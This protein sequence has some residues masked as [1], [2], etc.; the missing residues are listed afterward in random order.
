MNHAET[1][2]LLT[3]IASYDNRRI[4]DATVMAWQPIFADLPFDDCRA[5]VIAHFT[6]SDVYLM[7]VH[8]RRGA[9]ERDRE[10]RRL[11][12]E[13]R[14]RD[15]AIEAAVGAKDRSEETLA[16][17]ASVRDS[18]RDTGQDVLRP[19]EWVEWERKQARAAWA[20]A[21][22]NPHFKALPPPGGFD[23]DEESDHA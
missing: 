16:L 8:I 19:A 12:R 7:P 4:D 2:D 9:L 5:A 10:R 22:P 1:S 23:I 6:V 13:R 20:D 11:E 15:A 14:E 17:I 3:F 21:E 18:L